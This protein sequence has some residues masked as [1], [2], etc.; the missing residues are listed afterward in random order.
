MLNKK[1]LYEIILKIAV[2]ASVGIPSLV[3]RYWWNNDAIAWETYLYSFISL[4]QF[5]TTILY[6][7][8]SLV[9]I[10]DLI[11]IFYK[12]DNK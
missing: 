5:L 6:P 3:E 8:I 2:V 9:L 12:K 1:E 10:V 4:F 11:Y 7:I